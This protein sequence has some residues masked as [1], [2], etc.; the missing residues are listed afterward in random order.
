MAKK[1]GTLIIIGGAEDRTGSKTILTEVARR[2][3]KGK[4]VIATVATSLPEEL[5]KEYTEI[6]QSLGVSNIGVMNVRTR[7]DAHDE[8]NVEVL[9]DAGLVFFTGG[10]QLRITSQLGDSPVYLLIEET[11][12]RGG[13]IVGTSAGASVM[14]ETMIVTGDSGESATTTALV[15][16]PGMGLLRHVI[17]DQHFAERGRIGRLINAVAQN[18]R[19]L[20]VGIDEDT[21]LIVEGQQSFTVLGA[22]AVYVVD[23]SV[24]SSSNISEGSSDEILSCFDIKLHVLKQGD[25]FDLQVRRPVPDGQ[26]VIMAVEESPGG[27]AKAIGMVKRDGHTVP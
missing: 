13:T 19:N 1:D 6:F 17:V 7:A 18:P 20:G 15:M 9:R 12:R 3:G 24:I 16:G 10:D 23:G 5:A 8:K 22:G 21:A 11:Y 14:S 4:L 27:R 26:E 25:C 2:A